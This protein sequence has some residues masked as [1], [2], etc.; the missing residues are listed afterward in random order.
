MNIDNLLNEEFERLLK[1]EGSTVNAT[2][3]FFV[4]PT[5]NTYRI[6]IPGNQLLLYKDVIQFLKLVTVWQDDTIKINGIA[7][8]GYECLQDTTKSIQEIL[9]KVLG[10]TKIKFPE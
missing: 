8:N 1:E 7:W 6:Y 3:E 4:L 9:I 2:R 5:M 10:C